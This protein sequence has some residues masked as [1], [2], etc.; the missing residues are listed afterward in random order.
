MSQSYPWEVGSYIGGIE[1]VKVNIMLRIYANKWHVYA[2]LAILNP[3]A[4]IQIDQYA[5]SCTEMF[6]LMLGGR[7]EELRERIYTARDKVF[8]D[9]E[10]RQRRRPIF[11]SESVLDQFTLRGRRH[12]DGPEDPDTHRPSPRPIDP[13]LRPNSHLS[14]LAM[15]DS[16]AALNIRPFAHLSLAATPIFRMWIGIAEALYRSPE[17]LDAAIDASTHVTSAYRSDDLEFVVAARGW[18]QCVSFGSFKLYEER[19]MYTRKFFEERFDEAA[20]VGGNMIKM[21]TR[22]VAERQERVEDP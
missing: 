2:G 21:I 22:D 10:D 8:P 20:V 6:K 5:K 12:A 15:V 1:T 4:R 17:R 14:I 19:F 3:H 7:R 9:H 13:D 11:L 16:W 18:S